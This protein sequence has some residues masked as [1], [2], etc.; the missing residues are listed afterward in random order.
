MTDLCPNLSIILNV[1][2]IN[3]TIKRL[4]LADWLRRHYPKICCLQD[5]HFKHSDTGGFKV[6]QRTNDISKVTEQGV[7]TPISPQKHSFN[8]VMLQ[9][10]FMRILQSRELGGTPDKRKIEK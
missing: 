9:N 4:R 8:N 5:I 10:N 1:N 7:P 6:K 2:S 3:T